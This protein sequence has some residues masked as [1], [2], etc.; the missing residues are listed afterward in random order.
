M[1]YDQ[2][3]DIGSKIRRTSFYHLKECILVTQTA[4]RSSVPIWCAAVS[5]LIYA[6]LIGAVMSVIT[7]EVPSSVTQ[8]E[9]ERKKI[10][11]IKVLKYR[12]M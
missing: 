2:L 10:S 6:M 3:I 7:L 8:N 9:R 1:K 4:S 11:F 12:I 5:H